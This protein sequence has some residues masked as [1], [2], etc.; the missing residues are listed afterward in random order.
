M[1]LY[2]IYFISLFFVV[3]SLLF[4]VWVLGQI[5]TKWVQKLP[6]SDVSLTSTLYNQFP[7][8][9]TQC[10]RLRGLADH[11]Y[12]L[13]PVVASQPIQSST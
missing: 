8:C 5:H 6:E 7:Y 2:T 13:L 3:C 10:V 9:S 4:V 11:C 1:V 12:R